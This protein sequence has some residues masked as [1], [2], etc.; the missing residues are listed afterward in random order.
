MAGKPTLIGSSVIAIRLVFLMWLFFT[1]E[2]AY[3]I[4]LSNFGIYPRTFHGLIGIVMAP[5]LHGNVG[6]LISNTVP[7]LFLGAILFYFYNRIARKV[8]FICYLGTNILVWGIGRDANHIGASGLIYGLAFFLISFGLLRRDFWSLIISAL[9]IIT[10]GSILYGVMPSH[11]TISWESH[12][13]GALMGLFCGFV[14]YK[15]RKV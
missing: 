15:E 4:Y 5:M 14:F 6:H 11:P 2:Y 7:M 3:G 1:L 10:Y 8:F 13:S 12:L 9:V